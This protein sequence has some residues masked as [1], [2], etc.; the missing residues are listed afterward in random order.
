MSFS[1]V[2]FSTIGIIVVGLAAVVLIVS[3]AV[4]A[5]VGSKRE[6]GKP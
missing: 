3:L 4:S 1:H 5:L 2:D 6:V